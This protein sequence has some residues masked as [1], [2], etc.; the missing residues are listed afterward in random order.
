LTK[1]FE[2]PATT[3]KRTARRKIGF[4]FDNTATADADVSDTNLPPLVIDADGL[5]LL[6]EIENWWTL[7]PPRTI[8]T[9]HPGEMARLAGMETDEVQSNRWEIAARKAADWNAIVVLKGAHTVIAESDGRVAVLPFKTDALATAGTGD[10]LAGAITGLL[11]QGLSP[12]EAA[13]VGGY[14][15]G[16]AGQQ[17]AEWLGSTRA[18]IAGDVLDSLTDAIALVG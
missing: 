16:L 3:T 14:I 6:S 17:A 4:M 15:H 7:L 10:I 9:P 13:F 1:L 8:L 12:F 5:N 2:K 18:V 11:A